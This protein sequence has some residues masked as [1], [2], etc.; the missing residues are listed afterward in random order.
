MPIE[1]V[2]LTPKPNLLTTEE[3]LRLAR[4][5]ASHGVDKIR[6]TGGEPLVRKDIVSLV[7]HLKAVD[8]ISHVAM[9]T[10]GLTL[11]RSLPKLAEAGL[12]A[13][14]VSLD[15]LHDK[16]FEFVSRRPA[17]GHARVMGA[18]DAVLRHN[19]AVGVPN[20]RLK[21]GFI[22]GLLASTHAVRMSRDVADIHGE[23]A[24]FASVEEVLLL[25]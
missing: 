23:Q 6:L 19:E 16:K 9:T 15:T 3:I 17:A 24:D 11:E 21:A 8:G 18:L 22:F 1:G 2:P 20:I 25:F 5:F 7:K 14:N 13:V 4:V 10:N 12:D